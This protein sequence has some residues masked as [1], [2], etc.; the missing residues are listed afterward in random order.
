MTTPHSL[1]LNP[2]GCYDIK[3]STNLKCILF[4]VFVLS[5]W[6]LPI[7]KWTL[8]LILFFPYLIMAWYDFYYNCDR[9]FGPTYLMHFYDWLKPKEARQHL[10]YE[11]WCPRQ[12]KKVD[13]VDSVILIIFLIIF[14]YFYIRR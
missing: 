11:K 6:L 1:Q 7:N 9:Q 3:P 13:I 5:I 10:I 2:D 8:L 14:Y 4:T 12:R